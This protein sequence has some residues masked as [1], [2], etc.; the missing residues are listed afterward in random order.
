MAPPA[1]RRQLLLIGALLFAGSLVLYLANGKTVSFVRGGDSIP[2]RLIPFAVLQYATVTMDDFARPFASRGGYRWYVQE[3]Q[4][5]LVS[6]YPI[7]TPIV[8]VPFFVPLYAYAAATGRTSAEGLFAFSEVAEKITASTMTAVTVLLVWLALLRR[9]GWRRATVT[10][11]VL[12]SCSLLWPVASQVLWQHTAAAMLL[13]AAIL[14]A[15]SP[16]RSG[17]ALVI[18]LLLGLCFAVRPQSLPFVAGAAVGL[19]FAM[20]S[21]PLLERVKAGLFFIA[22][23]ALP[24]VPDFAYNRHYYGNWLGG[25]AMATGLFSGIGTYVFE[26]MSGLLFSPNRGLLVFMPVAVVGIVGAWRLVRE[27]LRDPVLAGL[28]VGSVLYFVLHAATATWAGGWCYGPRYLT[29]TLP[30]LAICSPLALVRPG[31]IALPV[32]AVAVAWSFL[33]MFAGSVFYPASDWNMRMEPDI[34]RASWNGAHFMPWED[35]QSW[36]YARS[37]ARGITP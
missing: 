16:V 15:S 29:E 8:A 28:A 2:N 11:V 1:S 35:Y 36:K 34:Q 5:H 13:A 4:G 32:L 19:V 31:K 3:R 30:V 6:Y 7:G 14:V 23:F 22:G 20:R 18:G 10:A 33:M 17:R 27:P 12:A 25:Y 37:V 26:G 9:T 24:V 21:R